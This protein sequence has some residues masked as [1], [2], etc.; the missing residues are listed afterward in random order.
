[1]LFGVFLAAYHRNHTRNQSSVPKI[2]TLILLVREG[3]PLLLSRSVGYSLHETRSNH[4]NHDRGTLGTGIYIAAVRLSELLHFIPFIICSSVYPSIVRAR[5]TNSRKYAQRMQSLCDGPYVTALLLALSFTF[6][7]APMLKILFRRGICGC[8]AL[9]VHIWSTIAVSLHHVESMA[10]GRGSAV[11]ALISTIIG[12]VSNLWL[13]L[14][15]LPS[16]GA[17]GAAIASASLAS[18]SRTDAP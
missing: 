12:L 10:G 2:S 8:S 11:V 3:W 9:Q 5:G 17:Q 6:L 7:T 4:V 13:N 18:L 16:H 14:L 15:L 1:M